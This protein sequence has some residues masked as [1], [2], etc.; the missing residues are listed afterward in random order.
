MQRFGGSFAPPITPETLAS[1]KSLFSSL[2][3]QYREATHKLVVVAETLQKTTL[4]IA[5]E[6]DHPSGRG[7]VKSIANYK[8][9]HPVWDALPWDYELSAIQQ[10]FDGLAPGPTRNAAFHL[11][12]YAKE[13]NLD[14]VPITTD[15]L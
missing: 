9:G 4:G 12:W 8:E 6:K 5:S 13:L 15:T 7:V 11:L 2:G 10:L 1:Y 3:A 14:R